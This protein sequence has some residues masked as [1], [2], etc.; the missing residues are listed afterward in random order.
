MSGLRLPS[1]PVTAGPVISHRGTARHSSP[2]EVRD[3]ADDVSSYSTPLPEGLDHGFRPYFPSATTGSH[4]IRD[5][6]SGYK[7]IREIPLTT[8]KKYLSTLSSLSIPKDDVVHIGSS[9]HQFKTNNKL[10]SFDM[11]STSENSYVTSPGTIE[12]KGFKPDQAHYTTL[13]STVFHSTISHPRETT[14]KSAKPPALP[15]ADAYATSIVKNK[16][17]DEFDRKQKDNLIEDVFITE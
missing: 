1:T 2:T 9:N 13:S 14:K 6:N 15:P 3:N 10:Q 11:D 8:E 5:K 12:D 7:D 16:F 17:P 4:A